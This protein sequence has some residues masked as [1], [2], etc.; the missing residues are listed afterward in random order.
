[1]LLLAYFF[2]HDT[3]AVEA[4]EPM[5]SSSPSINNA[6]MRYNNAKHGCV[7]DKVLRL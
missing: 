5:E 3:V 2:G 7:S 4:V 1:M 6:D